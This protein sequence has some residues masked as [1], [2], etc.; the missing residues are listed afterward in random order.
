VASLFYST[1]MESLSRSMDVELVAS[2]RW[3][4]LR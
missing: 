4:Y 1:D 3:V 2:I